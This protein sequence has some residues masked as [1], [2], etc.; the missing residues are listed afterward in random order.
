MLRRIVRGIGLVVP[1]LAL[2]QCADACTRILWNTNKLA[3]VV[4]RTMD[5]PESTEPILT[6]FPRGLKHNGGFI[7]PVETVKDNPAIWISKYGS[8]GVTVYGIG[9]ADGLNER[10]FSGH[11]LYLNAAGFGPRDPS[12]PAV[13]AGLW[14]QYLL[15]NAASV[16]E[17][18]VLESKIQIMPASA[19][20]HQANVHVAIEDASGDSAI[21]EYI[22]GKLVIHHGPQ[23]RVM[24]NDPPY[25]QQLALL[26][27]LDFSHPSSDTPLPGNVNPRDRFQ[28]ATYFETMLPEPTN[29]REAIAG[30]LAIARNV[31]V[32]FGAPYKGFGIYNTEYRTAIN[33]TTRRYFF[34]LTTVPNIIWADLS[35][36]DL[37]PG[38]PVMVLDPDDINLSGNVTSDFHRLDKAPF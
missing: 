7:G 28:R 17:A 14:L 10:G 1:W 15:D 25:D 34:E 18:L 24:T 38:A 19:R 31:S 32:P 21:I 6:I 33:L 36:F 13:N 4:A 27:A 3:V 11:M 35:K 26:K 16:D 22:D 9:T 20:G 5:W 12:K 30:V 29:E 23:Y 8:I 2:L 37:A